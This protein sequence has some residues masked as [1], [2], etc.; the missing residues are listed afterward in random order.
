MKI[1]KNEEINI[2]ELN[3]LLGTIGWEINPVEKLER[4]LELSWGWLTARNKDDKLVGF[5][6]VLS[7]GIKHAYILRLLVHSDF[8]GK[9]IGKMIV[10]ELMDI[11][12]ELELNPVLITKPA[13]E[14]FYKNFGL[15]R[16][17]NG[18]IS[19]FKWE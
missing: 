4:S 8:Q 3:E 1:I 11:L 6:Q 10:K 17:N 18:F 12:K 13:E 15:G 14:S 5:V 9:G 2:E 7:D 16:E 19:L